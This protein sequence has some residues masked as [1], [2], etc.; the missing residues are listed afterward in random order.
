[1]K[2]PELLSE[3]VWSELRWD[4]KIIVKFL[5]WLVFGWKR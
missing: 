1:M 3:E 5:L 4:D 2:K